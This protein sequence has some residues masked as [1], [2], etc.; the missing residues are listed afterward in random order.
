MTSSV[1]SKN[2]QRQF[3]SPNS[4][5]HCRN[6]PLMHK[7]HKIL[8]HFKKKLGSIIFLENLLS[9]HNVTFVINK[10]SS[11]ETSPACSPEESLFFPL[12][13]QHSSTKSPLPALQWSAAK[14]QNRIFNWDW[15]FPTFSCSPKTT[16][17]HA[18]G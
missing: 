4:L 14:W 10:V 15:S 17:S 5:K 6:W 13:Q 2:P 16:L 11:V 1:F 12:F 9:L 8:I 18:G 7:Y 3:S